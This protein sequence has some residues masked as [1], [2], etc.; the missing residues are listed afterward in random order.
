[1]KFGRC[2]W[3]P[4]IAVLLLL[5]G[6]F[7][8]P[9]Q[10]EMRPMLEGN[11]D[12][13]LRYYPDGT[14]FVITNGSEFFNRP[15]YCA[16][17]AC[18]VDGGDKP[19]FSLYLPGRGGNLRLAVVLNGQTK[20]LHDAQT[21]VTRY[22]P[23]SLLY[24]VQ[25]PS[26]GG[27]PIRLTVLPLADVKGFVLR[28]EYSG[29]AGS[30]ALLFAFGGAGGDGGR[31]AGDIGCEREPVSRFFQLRPENCRSNTINLGSNSFT[32]HGRRGIV[33]GVFSTNAALAAGDARYWN[34]P[35]LLLS[36]ASP[37]NDLPLVVAQ[38]PLSDTKPVFFAA[39][40]VEEGAALAAPRELSQ[41]FDAAEKHRQSVAEH[42]RIE[43]PDGFLNA[44][45]SALCVAA[46]GVWDAKDQVFMHGAVAWRVRL[47]GWR[48]PYCGDALGWHERTRQHFEYFAARQNTDSI[49]ATLPPAD[50]S[51]NLARNE[52]ALHS[53]G[54]LS[55]NHYDMN[56]VAIDAF[57]RH[58]LWTGD[59]E[60]AKRMWP[61]LERH[62]AWERRLFR[63]PLGPAG[64]PLYEAYCCIWA[65]D[66]LQYDGGGAAHA[67][68]YN[69]Y[70]NLMAA[71]LAR[72]LG[73][74][75]GAYETEAQA[76]LKA[77]QSSL[78]MPEL[79]AFAESKDLLGL[80][81]IRPSASLWTFYHTVDSEVPSPTQAWQMTR[82]VDS[83]ISRIPIRG[84]GVP[85][86]N[87]FT[88]PTTRWM[89]YLWSLN[90]VVMAESTHTALGFWQA[91]RADEALA[92]FK[93]ALLDSM[94]LGLCPGNAGM[95]TW[96]DVV[97]R[98]SQRDFA[99]G[100]GATSRALIEGLFGVSPNALDGELRLRPGFPASWEHASLAHPDLTFTFHR[101]DSA[102]TYSVE[103]R[104]PKPMRLR[105][106][107]PARRERIA[108][109]TLNGKPWP[110]TNLDQSIGQP[111]IEL[112]AP[113]AAR[114][115]IVATWQG[116]SPG[117]PLPPL[118]LADGDRLET[119]VAPAIIENLL[120]PQQALS[121]P[122]VNGSRLAANGKGPL[123]ATV[124]LRVH[125][126]GLRWRIPLSLD[127]R[128]PYE[129][130]PEPAQDETHLAFRLR[131][132]T[133][134]D[135]N[136]PV[137]IQTE[138]GETR[139]DLRIPAHTNSEPVVL[140]SEGLLPGSNP[141]QI[142]PIRDPNPNSD[143]LLGKGRITNWKLRPSAPSVRFESVNLAGALNDKL[144][145]IFKNEYRAPR[146]QDTCSLQTPINGLG[147]WC[148]YNLNFAI[149]D[150]GVRVLALRQGNRIEP[151]PGIPLETPGSPASNNIAFVSQW[152]NYRSSLTVPLAGKARRLYL[153]MAGS[154]GP[155]Q[156]QY[157]NGQILVR[158]TDGSVEKLT[159][160]NPGNWWPVEQDYFIDDF[161]FRRPGAIPPRVDLASGRVRL[162]DSREF[163]GKGGRIPGGSATL[164]DLPL[165]PGKEL[166]S[167]TVAALANQVVIGLMSATL[168]RP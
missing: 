20:W 122:A 69:Y 38:V 17:T 159:L 60:Y 157:D 145:R 163:K 9:A 152:E 86:D 65:S 34:Q 150:S 25:D 76:I 134:T 43:T 71:R 149:D 98:E 14:D 107:I 12:R 5:A 35:E 154:T 3:I 37:T 146:P 129:L 92:L 143:L 1:M 85:A 89:P 117:A 82:Y 90:N 135:F 155:M 123:Q 48:G 136:E 156:S 36:A 120:D 138:A 18:R 13:P 139:R 153:L 62:L 115:E 45:A 106:Q 165:N 81:Q 21:I 67:T 63:R 102:D 24:T 110:W 11:L 160:R 95:C 88:L 33:S 52:A 80:G 70:H 133:S 39:G 77:M 54:D 121:V 104:F 58:L 4:W 26:F 99:D 119:S 59:L 23:G 61:V 44:A 127:I 144:A 109:L 79:G 32:L 96:Y 78:W 91:G 55:H 27:V 101:N 47:L 118:V 94:Y 16:N 57:L 132:N 6:V 22:R 56:L 42:I 148:D 10:P 83:R 142:R 108:S 167:L 137:I 141:I 29:N 116:P 30:P 84:P 100:I 72:L 164:L 51:V 74:D 113:A 28:A 40:P 41:L 87:C 50:E 111:R 130:Q 66:D 46:D 68:A 53:N 147:G 64:N 49:P 128:A 131:N 158:Y 124:F 112:L 97:R 8:S 15:L 114:A 162:L 2:R 161:A 31:R 140:A 103:P 73:K 19:E 168:A 105:L 126:G 75:P 166:Q 93:G 151:I 7:R 125:Q